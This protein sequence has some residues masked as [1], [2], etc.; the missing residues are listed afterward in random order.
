MPAMPLAKASYRRGDNIPTRLVNMLY[1]AD[2]TNTQDQ[3][4][5]IS[6]FGLDGE[7]FD[8]L[9][10]GPIR[11]AC[12][13]EASDFAWVVSGTALYKVNADGTAT[14]IGTGT[15]ITGT[16]L[17][18]MATNGTNVM[19]A[20]G[21]Y[22]TPK[23]YTSS[24]SAP[25]EVSTPDSVGMIDVVCVSGVFLFLPKDSQRVYFSEPYAITI[26]ALNYFSAELAPDNLVALVTNG[27]ETHLIGRTSTEVWVPYSDADLPFQRVEGRLSRGGCA[28]RH[29]ACLVGDAAC[30]V[31]DDNVLYRRGEPF[32]DNDMTAII[33]K[34][35]SGLSDWTLNGGLNAWSYPFLNHELY[36]LNIPGAGTWAFD[37]QTKQWFELQS[38]DKAL[39]RLATAVKMPDGA[40]I[41]GD[42]YDGTIWKLDAEV[43][44]DGDDPLIRTFTGLVE[45]PVAIANGCAGLDCTTGQASLSH[46]TDTP[47]MQMR[48]SDDGGK[49]W[50]G[51]DSASLGHQGDY[52]AEPVWRRLGTI[53]R[54]GRLYEFRFSDAL[55]LTVRKGWY[56]EKAAR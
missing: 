50:S 21:T 31:G 28:S 22:A 1:E 54:P 46:P 40:W 23:L 2:P 44:A 42:R 47:T 33:A 10:D 48:T 8:A 36:V 32:G 37:F 26:D 53:R 51:W 56:N 38:Y 43:Y 19:I 30:W 29:A 18:R 16:A 9:G 24:G 49:T 34:A 7:T 27:D 45:T 13:E 35:R 12:R 3:V 39:F 52:L 25:T 55:P 20:A 41:G 17:V 5:L 6:R 15:E 14:L 11:G 4:S